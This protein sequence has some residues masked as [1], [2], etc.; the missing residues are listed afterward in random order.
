MMAH[1]EGSMGTKMWRSGRRDLK[2]VIFSSDGKQKCSNGHTH[3]GS[4]VPAIR[5]CLR[6]INDLCSVPEKVVSAILDPSNICTSHSSIKEK[7]NSME[8][9]SGMMQ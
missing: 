9:S 6:N 3:Y 5:Y 7:A 8:T 4:L 1:E 2:E